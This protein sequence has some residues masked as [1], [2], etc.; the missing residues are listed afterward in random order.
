MNRRKFIKGI[1]ATGAIFLMPVR[2]LAKKI[3]G[4]RRIKP[5]YIKDVY[6]E[7]KWIG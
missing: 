1:F 6:K 5:F 4:Y 7:H 3:K 2:V